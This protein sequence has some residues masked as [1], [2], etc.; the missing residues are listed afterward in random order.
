MSEV[1]FSA[2][3]TIVKQGDLGDSFYVMKSGTC[4][5]TEKKAMGKK[6]T[7]ADLRENDFFG[8]LSLLGGAG[9]ARP[10]TVSAKST[11]CLAHVSKATF[12]LKVG[13][14]RDIVDEDKQMRDARSTAVSVF[15]CSFR[16]LSNYLSIHLSKTSETPT[17]RHPRGVF[18]FLRILL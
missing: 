13:N 16:S 15:R 5:C 9:S 6:K 1:T 12:E 10:Y 8:E 2:G 18:L 3:E 4:Q 11:T 14:L 17:W 7:H